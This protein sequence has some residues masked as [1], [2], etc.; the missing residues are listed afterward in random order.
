MS[1]LPPITDVGR[2]IQVSIRLYGGVCPRYGVE[3]VGDRLGVQIIGDRDIVVSSADATFSITY[4]KDGHAPLLVAV[5]GIGRSPEPAFVTFCAPA[6]K[7]AYQK[8]RA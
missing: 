5:N 7:P 1:A 2:H 3:M 8:A 6:W 4:R